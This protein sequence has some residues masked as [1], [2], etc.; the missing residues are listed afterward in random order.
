MVKCITWQSW[1]GGLLLGCTL[2]SPIMAQ[3]KGGKVLQLRQGLVVFDA[4]AAYAVNPDGG[5]D[6]LD[7]QTGKLLWT[8]SPT[9]PP[10]GKDGNLTFGPAPEKSCYWPL[11]VHGRLL[12]TRE[13]IP[14]KGNL[15]RIV[16]LDLDQKGKVAKHFAPIEFPVVWWNDPGSQYIGGAGPAPIPPPPVFRCENSIEGGKLLIAWEGIWSDGPLPGSAKQVKK[17]LFEVDLETGKGRVLPADKK[18]TEPVHIVVSDRKFTVVD[19]TT[20]TKPS[21][22]IFVTTTVPNLQATDTTTGKLA[23]QMKLRGG[24]TVTINSLA[25]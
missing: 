23:W 8:A 13:R 17:G 21:P 2:A 4:Q 11:A 25:P 1:L 7:L 20:N 5:I 19:S 3:D 10:K 9:I 15:V 24:S 14:Q 16:L 6:A 12:V 18:I 22:G